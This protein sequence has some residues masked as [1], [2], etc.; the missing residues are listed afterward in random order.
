MV[1][2]NSNGR[3]EGEWNEVNAICERLASIEKI[4]GSGKGSH[5]E[6]VPFSGWREGLECLKGKHR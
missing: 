3:S 6:I 1:K 2:P 4:G 5:Y